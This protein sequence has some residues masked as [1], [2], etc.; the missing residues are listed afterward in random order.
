M[1]ASCDENLA[2]AVP[3]CS[4]QTFGATNGSR[5]LAS[6]LPSW[7]ESIT[8][9]SS[10][11]ISWNDKLHGCEKKFLKKKTRPK[12]LNRG[13]AINKACKKHSRPLI[14]SFPHGQR[15]MLRLQQ[16]PSEDFFVA[17]LSFW[18]GFSSDKRLSGFRFCWHSS[19]N[20]E[21]SHTFEI[22]DYKIWL[23]AS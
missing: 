14:F 16:F 19:E 18:V 20:Q 15:P 13:F 23:R 17:R 5:S 7:L 22:L 21:S 2:Q 8:E 11:A 10:N 6:S 3:S 4:S 1:C 12:W 9:T